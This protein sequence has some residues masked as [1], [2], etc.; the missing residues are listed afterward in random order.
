MLPDLPPEFKVLRR[1]AVAV[2]KTSLLPQVLSMNRRFARFSSLY[3]LKKS[4]AWILW[5]HSKLLKQ[6]TSSGPLTVIELT[7]AETAIIKAVQQDFFPEEVSV[8]SDSTTPPKRVLQVGGRLR[9]APIEFETRHPVNLL[10]DSHVTPLL[11]EQ[12]H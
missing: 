7:C 12:H 1:T 2:T 11:I 8:L 4:V 10:P 3:W 9:R 5:L 6:K